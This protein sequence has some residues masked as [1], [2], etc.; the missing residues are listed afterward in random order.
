M[1]IIMIIIQSHCSWSLVIRDLKENSFHA[2]NILEVMFLD[3][4]LLW[5]GSFSLYF[6]FKV[7]LPN[8]FT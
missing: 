4:F 2:S 7:Q 6:H 3:S 1:S 8:Q 5:T